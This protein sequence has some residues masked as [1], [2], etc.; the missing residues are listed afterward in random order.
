MCIIFLCIII[1]SIY[2]V[3]FFFNIFYLVLIFLFC[4]SIIFLIFHK[5]IIV[6]IL[7]WD[8]LG[9]TSFFLVFYYINWTSINRRVVTILTN[10][11]GDIFIIF[12]VVFLILF[13]FEK[14]LFFLSIFFLIL[15]FGLITKR[16]QTPFRSW[17][18]QAISA[19]TPTRALVHSRTLVTAGIYLILKYFYFFFRFYYFFF[20]FIIGAI[21]LIVSGSCSFFEKDLKKIIALRTLNQLGF[22]IF[23]LSFGNKII[24]FFHLLSH[25]FFK[26]CLFLQMGFFIH[27]NFS[28]QDARLFSFFFKHNKLRSFFFFFCLL[29]ICG[30]S[31]LRGFVSK[32]FVLFRVVYSNFYFY[33]SFFVFVIVFFTIFYRSLLFFRIFITKIFFFFLDFSKLIFFASVILFFFGTFFGL[34]FSKSFFI[35]CFI[36]GN[37]EICFF[38]FYIFRFFLFFYFFVL[39]KINKI[40]IQDSLY[41]RINYQLK[42]KRIFFNYFFLRI[43]DKISFSS[44][45]FFNKNLNSFYFILFFFFI[46]ILSI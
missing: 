9:V 12:F 35:Y 31:F 17:L 45:F 27:R 5:R 24:I 28:N 29:S 34:W 19:P 21:T 42:K 33:F 13:N 37:K 8:G 14:N 4:V 32:E 7:G 43:I 39:F 1:F 38:F 46:V 15:F 22:I 23:S 41:K 3:K 26:S 40:I 36:F 2:Y 11:L 30:L 20:F 6:L 44:I 25:A 16:A 10:R 18:P